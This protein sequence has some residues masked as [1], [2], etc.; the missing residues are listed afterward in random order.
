VTVSTSRILATEFITVTITAS[1]NYSK[2]YCNCST[3]IVFSSLLDFQLTQL[4]VRVRVTLRLAVYCQSVPLGDKSLETHGQQ[5]LS[6]LNPSGH[7]P[8]VTSSLTTG[9]VCRLQL[10]LAFASAVI[11]FSCLSFET[12]PTWR[13]K[14]P[15]LHPPGTGW[16]SYNPRHWVPF[17]SPPTTCRATLEVFEN[18][19]TLLQL[20]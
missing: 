18:A 10:L 19:S 12:P 13:P 6:Q 14:S 16:P 15:Y 5:F 7:S 17:S 11:L 1:L 4:T 2:Y 3:H 20:T 9:W 8:H